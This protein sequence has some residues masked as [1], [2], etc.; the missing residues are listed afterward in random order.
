MSGSVGTHDQAIVWD[1]PCVKI[2]R[3]K[4]HPA[5]E[6]A[7]DPAIDGVAAWFAERGFGLRLER[8]RADLVWAHLTTPRTG[9][10]FAPKYGR[11]DTP[12]AAALRARERYEDEQ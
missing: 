2:E 3:R 11:G 8:E 7:S 10:V 9:A 1:S 5:G 12:V 6:I 4:S